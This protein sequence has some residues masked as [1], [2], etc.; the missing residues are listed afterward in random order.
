MNLQ[1]E[2]EVAVGVDLAAKQR[3]VAARIVSA[4]AAG[5]SGF[6]EDLL[7]HE[8]VDVTVAFNGWRESK[9]GRWEKKHKRIPYGDGRP[10]S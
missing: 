6:G 3:Y 2:V 7:D 8:S 5:P 10:S 1:V 9:V 4:E